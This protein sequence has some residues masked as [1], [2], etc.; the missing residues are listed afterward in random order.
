MLI[1]FFTENNKFIKNAIIRMVKKEEITSLYTYVS[2]VEY[3][4]GSFI[5]IYYAPDTGLVGVK[6]KIED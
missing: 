3:C 6:Y 1:S 2:Y 5:D 4:D